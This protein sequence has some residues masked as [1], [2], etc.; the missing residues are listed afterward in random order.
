M[1][2]G[3]DKGKYTR[4]A[5]N[6]TD[7]QLRA[8]LWLVGEH[9]I[10]TRQ[11]LDESDAITAGDR[12]RVRAY[13]MLLKFHRRPFSLE[14]ARAG[15]RDAVHGIFRCADCNKDVT[16]SHVDDYQVLQGVWM[17]YGVGKGYLC[18]VCLESRIGRPITKAELVDRPINYD[19]PVWLKG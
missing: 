12:R 2:D 10:R 1:I 18:L 3:L 7:D 13:N 11:T 15:I 9:C 8:L 4:W 5:E 17:T 19:H 16:E 14:E 6:L